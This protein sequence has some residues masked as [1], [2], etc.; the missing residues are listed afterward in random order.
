MQRKYFGTTSNGIPIHIFHL[1]S[2]SGV[3]VRVMEYGASLVSIETPDEHGRA[4]PIVLGFDALSGYLEASGTGVGGDVREDVH[5]GLCK[6]HP[7]ETSHTIYHPSHGA[8]LGRYAG[9]IGDA[10]FRLSGR[11]HSV[12]NLGLPRRSHAKATGLDRAVWWGEA[13]SEGVRF[14]YRSPAGAEGYP[15]AVDC[16]V[17]YR[18]DARGELRIDYRGTTD[19]LT[20]ID[21]TSQIFFNLNDAGRSSVR[22]HEL[23]IASDEIVE[24]DRDGAPTGHFRR[25]TGSPLDFG[26]AKRLAGRGDDA[27]ASNQTD[28]QA[29]PFYVLR[30]SAESPRVVA[31]VCHPPSGR[32]LELS[33]TQPGLCFEIGTTLASKHGR[34]SHGLCLRPQ[35][36]PDAPNHR[37]FPS[38]RLTPGSPYHQ[39]TLL[40]F[41]IGP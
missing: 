38:P 3:T 12:S 34:Q 9:Q 25:I 13:L 28:N 19:D 29:D 20:V 22:D 5:I 18:L 11:L 40:R 2:A 14:H 10:A 30:K 6:D 16:S 21:L 23:T 36:L 7:A 8:V 26:S 39:S 35:N 1:E 24:V 4:V 15:G 32:W 41:G 17:E 33:T 27:S 37:H 31:R